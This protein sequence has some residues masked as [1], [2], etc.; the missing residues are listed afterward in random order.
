VNVDLQRAGTAEHWINEEKNVVNGT[1]LSW[2]DFA[3]N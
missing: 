1:R 2:R 3:D